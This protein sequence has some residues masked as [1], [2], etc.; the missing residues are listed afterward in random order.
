MAFPRGVNPGVLNFVCVPEV[1]P[2]TFKASAN[3]LFLFPFIYFPDIKSPS[4]LPFS[5]F[6]FMAN[7]FFYFPDIK[8]PLTLLY[9]ISFRDD[10]LVLVVVVVLV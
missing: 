10:L 7:S 3:S 1:A 8:P 9:F 5:F 4:T 2:S 6:P